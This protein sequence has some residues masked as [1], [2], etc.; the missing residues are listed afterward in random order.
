MITLLSPV[1]K[2]KNQ[3]VAETE[4]VDCRP[5]DIAHTLPPFIWQYALQRRNVNF[6][7]MP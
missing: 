7:F 4:L 1:F 3:A 5:I 2:I 6:S